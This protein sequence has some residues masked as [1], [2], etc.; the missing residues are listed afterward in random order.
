MV[1]DPHDFNLRSLLGEGV[2]LNYNRRKGTLSVSVSTGVV[3]ATLYL[4]WQL[5]VLS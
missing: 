3:V 2:K 5:G 4:L 1:S